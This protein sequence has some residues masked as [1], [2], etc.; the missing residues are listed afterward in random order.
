MQHLQN[1][2]SKAARSAF[3]MLSSYDDGEANA[4][5]VAIRPDSMRLGLLSQRSYVAPAC[6]AP[7]VQN[8]LK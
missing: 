8:N 1:A 6:E 2:Q 3:W 7:T 5:S 4:L